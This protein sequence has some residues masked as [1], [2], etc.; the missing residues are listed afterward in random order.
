VQATTPPGNHSTHPGLTC[1]P[2]QIPAELKPAAQWVNYRTR[3][4]K[5]GKLD[6]IPLD[7]KPAAQLANAAVDDAA[8]WGTFVQA[9]ANLK[10]PRVTGLR[11]TVTADEGMTFLDWDGVRDPATGEVDPDALAEAVALDTY[12]EISPSGCGL[13]AVVYGTLPAHGRNNQK[14]GRECYNS[15]RFVTFTGHHLPGTPTTVQPRQAELDAWHLRWF[16]PPPAPRAPRSPIVPSNLDDVALLEKARGAKDGDKFDRLWH[17]DNSDY[18]GDESAAD[19]G[20]CNMFRFWWQGDPISVDR[21]FRQSGRYR[22]KWD[23]RHYANGQTYGEHTI[24]TAC[25]RGDVYSPPSSRTLIPFPTLGLVQDERPAVQACGTCP[26]GDVAAQLAAR[27]AENA[28]LRAGIVARDAALADQDRELTQL[29]SLHTTIMEVQANSKLKTVG[30][31]AIATMLAVAQRDS[32]QPTADGFYKVR[33]GALSQRAGVS[34]QRVSAHLTQLDELGVL[35]KRTEREPTQIVDPETGEISERMTSAIFVRVPNIDQGAAAALHPLRTLD[36]PPPVSKT[37]WGGARPHCPDHPAAGLVEHRTVHCAECGRLVKK[38]SDRTLPAEDAAN[39]LT[40][41]TLAAPEP[42]AVQDDRPACQ[43]ERPASDPP[44]FERSAPPVTTPSV[45]DYLSLS[46]CKAGPT[47]L[48]H[49]PHCRRPAL[50]NGQ[51]SCTCTPHT[52]PLE[53]EHDPVLEVNPEPPPPSPV[54]PPLPL[55]CRWCPGCRAQGRWCP[56]AVKAPGCS[57]CLRPWRPPGEPAL[58]AI[59]GGA[60]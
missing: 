2:D 52:A 53:P 3:P 44:A 35:E 56:I 14:A 39:P 32:G 15:G 55:G 37:T 21:M 6:K 36:P 4:K 26:Y 19:L 34:A 57:R 1:R 23:E 12:T 7:P 5:N 48:P 20:L 47:T 58:A 13:R 45:E 42:P 10:H 18:G 40:W 60:E 50:P 30:R 27:E 59:A 46:S 25:A 43:D 28:A 38:Y 29:R 16:G 8:T 9:E 49:C 51:P 31:T 24:E 33:L 17:G 41:P 11:R 54:E 22:D